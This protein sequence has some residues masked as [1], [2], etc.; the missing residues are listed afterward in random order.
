MSLTMHAL[1]QLVSWL[2]MHAVS[3][4]ILDVAFAEEQP[5]IAL[6]IVHPRPI[7]WSTVMRGVSDALLGAKVTSE[8]LP[9]V[10]F[11]EWFEALELRSKT[12]D[13]DDLSTIVSMDRQSSVAFLIV[14]D[15]QPAIK[16]LKFFRVLSSADV[17]NRKSGR[18]D[19]Q[20]GGF[21]AFSTEKSQAASP[22]INS[23]P[24]LSADDMQRWI[25][26][27]SAKKFFE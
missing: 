7:E 11:G 13:V 5:T 1:I 14:S 15:F 24:L 21:P 25:G 17:V 3:T 23:L 22:T 4:A 9:L 8:L 19:V 10:P 18:K 26:Y 20:A 12:A 16:L 6:N 2:P 27:W